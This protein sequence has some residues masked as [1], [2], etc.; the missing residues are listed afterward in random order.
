MKVV[1]GRARPYFGICTENKN[2]KVT[3][4][5]TWAGKLKNK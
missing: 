3:T 5:L 1:N 4:Y 2:L